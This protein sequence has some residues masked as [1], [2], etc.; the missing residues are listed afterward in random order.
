MSG[1]RHQFRFQF[2]FKT[3]N[4]C[5]GFACSSEV[6]PMKPGGIAVPPQGN[7]VERF[8]HCGNRRRPAPLHPEDFPSKMYSCTRRSVNAVPTQ[9]HE[10]AL[11]PFDPAD[12]WR[13]CPCWAAAVNDMRQQIIRTVGQRYGLMLAHHPVLVISMLQSFLFAVRRVHVLAPEMRA[14]VSRS[15]DPPGNGSDC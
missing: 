3:I 14:Y 5:A 9:V 7:Y 10:C 13:D 6:D 4:H 12:S 15:T 2:T 8:P 11:E 1:R